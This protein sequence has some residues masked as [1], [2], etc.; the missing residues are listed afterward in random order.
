[1]KLFQ[2]LENLSKEEFKVLRKAVL[3]P[4][5]TTNEKVVVLFEQLR[6][7]YPNF[8]ASEEGRRR[9]F[10]KIFKEAA[11]NNYKLRRLFSELTRV[12]EDFFIHLELEQQKVTRQ[13]RLINVYKKRGLYTLFKKE[14][15]GLL[16]ELDK[17]NYQNIEY[18]WQKIQVLKDKYFHPKYDKYDKKEHTLEEFDK[19]LDAYF[20]LLRI[21]LTILLKNKA[22]ILNKQFNYPFLAA[23]KEEGVSG[24]LKEN[25]L[26]QFYLQ[27][28]N[29]V[30]EEK[31]VNFLAFEKIFF[32]EFPALDKDDKRIFYG[33]INNYITR[34]S[35]S[36]NPLF[37]PKLR[38]KWNIF[39]LNNG[40]F[41]QN[42]KMNEARFGSI[43]ILG[44][45]VGDF[46]MVDDFMQKYQKLLDIAD[47]ENTIIYYEGIYHFTKGDFDKVLSLYA[48]FQPPL[49]HRLRVRGIISRALFVNF[50]QDDSYY[51]T[52]NNF[53]KTFEVYLNRTDYFPRH[54][55]NS[56]KN[57]IKIIRSLVDKIICSESTVSI[58][59]GFNKSIEGQVFYAKNWL[60]AK[61]ETL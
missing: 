19:H 34:E 31:E 49:I 41:I 26:L 60:I 18:H 44:C 37:S 39:G 42:G 3:S 27:S 14:I 30:E 50:L 59:T 57:F 5:F 8:D 17:S 21:Q 22:T 16:A 15:A 10:S 6:S 12:V 45:I 28:L 55:V 58:K 33:N 48:T 35:N 4:L 11:Y 2:L 20:S 13:K 40:L 56:Y 32:K 46:E 47:L 51:E 61:V 9:L 53:L 7:L 38:Q 1:M 24:R 25:T 43:M 54:Q 29:L 36:A 52:L 23:V